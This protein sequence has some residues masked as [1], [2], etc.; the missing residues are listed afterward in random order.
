MFSRWLFQSYHRNLTGKCKDLLLKNKTGLSCRY[1]ISPQMAAEYSICSNLYFIQ[2]QDQRG[3]GNFI[4]YL[5]VLNLIMHR[6]KKCSYSHLSFSCANVSRVQMICKTCSRIMLTKEEK[7]Q[8]LDILKRPNLAYLQK[9]GLKKKISD[10]C[11]KRTLCLNCTAFNGEKIHL[12]SL[13]QAQD[14]VI[15]SK[16]LLC[17]VQ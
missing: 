12:H 7:L 2:L 13:Y 11:R 6:T 3:K 9:R 10:K 5:C 17:Q 16:S 14:I 8:F 1:K 15:Q 4:H